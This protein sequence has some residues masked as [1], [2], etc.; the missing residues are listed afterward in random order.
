MTIAE[1]LGAF[2]LPLELE[3]RIQSQGIKDGKPWGRVIAFVTARAI[4]DRLDT[5][6]GPANWRN[7]FRPW[8][9]GTPGVLCG[10]SLR[11]D[12][13][14]IT[15]WDGAEQT[16]V[17]PLKGGLSGALKRSAVQWGV[18][19]YLY[20]LPEGWAQF[21]ESGQYRTKIDGQTYRWDPPPIPRQFLPSERENHPTV[22][23]PAQQLYEPGG[24]AEMPGQ[25][26]EAQVGSF[27]PTAKQVAFYLRLVQ[28][29]V[30]TDEERR[31]ARTWLQTK[32]TKQTA[33]DQIDWLKRK[34][35]EREAAGSGQAT[36]GAAR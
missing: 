32:A 30:F 23:H 18:G 27:A 13:E 15:K 35:E 25:A 8:E 1:Q 29:P 11:L 36:Q 16:D 3:W 26:P 17:E 9:I 21:S 4:Q 20:D 24:A 31:R 28:S 19:R 22:E 14:W 12:G 33:K 6:V 2:F 7:E 10:L 5:V 34:I